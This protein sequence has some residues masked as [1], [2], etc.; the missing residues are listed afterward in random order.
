MTSIKVGFASTNDKF[1]TFHTSELPTPV[2]EAVQALP[3][4]VQV[5]MTAADNSQIVGHTTR[6]RAGVTKDVYLETLLSRC[7]AISIKS[8]RFSHGDV[9]LFA[10]V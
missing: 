4:G 10:T 6:V 1:Y 8:I 2:R 7:H 3:H 5:F 9:E